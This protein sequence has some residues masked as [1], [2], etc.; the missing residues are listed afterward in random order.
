MIGWC[1]IVWKSVWWCYHYKLF[2]GV[3]GRARDLRAKALCTLPPKMPTRKWDGFAELSTAIRRGFIIRLALDDGIRKAFAEIVKMT[4]ITMR[5]W[6][7]YII[8]TVLLNLWMRCKWNQLLKMQLLLSLPSWWWTPCNIK[9]QRVV[10]G[11][12]LLNLKPKQQ[13][14]QLQKNKNGKKQKY[15]MIKE[16]LVSYE[17]GQPKKVQNKR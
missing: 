17:I 11:H 14:R 7:L 9:H 8:L 16:N 1:S 6:I 10:V 3:G 13:Q 12:N 5:N 2:I 4:N 15:E